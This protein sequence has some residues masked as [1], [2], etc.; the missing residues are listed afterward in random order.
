MDQPTFGGRK[1]DAFLF[2]MD[3]TILN[4]IPAAERVWERWATEHGLDVESFLL[5]IHG[6]RAS[7]TVA[8]FG[9]AGLD[10]EAE[11]A[12]ITEAEI[13][14]LEGVV[15]IPGAGAFLR[16]LPPSKWAVVTS[17]PLA[18]ARARITAA[19]LPI[20]SVLITAEDVLNGKPD[21]E[22]YLLAAER[23]GADIKRCLI[24]EDAEAGILAAKAAGAELVVV[25]PNDAASER[26]TVQSFE[27]L[28]YEVSRR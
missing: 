1:Y 24:F 14:E 2:D 7:E 12:K 25:S 17:A 21:P 6:V 15:E 8:R 18:L 16:S 3:G 11:A 4:S 22:G 23:L 10:A 9:P 26:R 5:K 27:E 20:P 13:N 19:G 28:D